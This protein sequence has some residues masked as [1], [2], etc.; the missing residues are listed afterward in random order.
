M[1]LHNFSKHFTGQH[2][3]DR[4]FHRYV[5]IFGRDTFRCYQ[6]DDEALSYFHIF[7]SIMSKH[8]K[9]MPCI[10]YIFTFFHIFRPFT[11]N[12]RLMQHI[13]KSKIRAIPSTR[14]GTT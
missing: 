10:F 13:D 3:G 6:Y 5:G 11:N 7:M 1:G 9:E 8:L 14:L 4:C 2:F 12:S